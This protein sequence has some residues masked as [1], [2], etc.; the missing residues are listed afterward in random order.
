MLNEICEHLHNFFD[1]RDGEYIDRTAGT[2]AISDGLISPLSS[3]LIAGQY[4]RIVGSLLNDG[5]YLLPSNFTISTLVNETF[6]G[7]IFGLAIPRDLVTLDSEITA[8]VAANPASGYVSESFGG[9][10]GTK[11]TGANGAALSWKS[12]YAARLNRWRKI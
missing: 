2:F 12:V 9:W 5:I 3:S 8:W 7:A 11:A 4:I 1:A 6:T 10:S